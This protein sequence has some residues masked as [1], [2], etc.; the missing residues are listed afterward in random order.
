MPGGH[1]QEPEEYFAH[2]W[3]VSVLL[4]Y[5]GIEIFPEIK[6]VQFPLIF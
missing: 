6:T 1:E 3:D 4:G 5:Q 2:L